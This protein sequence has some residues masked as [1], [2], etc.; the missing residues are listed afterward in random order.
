MQKLYIT[1]F[2]G[3]YSITGKI[4][5][6][7]RNAIVF[8]SCLL[9]TAIY[10]FWSKSMDASPGII[11]I[12]GS[13]ITA[14]MTVFSI[15]GPMVKVRKN[16][17]PYFSMVLFGVGILLIGQLHQVGDGYVMYALDLIF[18]FPA[19]YFIWNSRGDHDTLYKMIAAGILLAGIISFMYCFYLASKGELVIENGRLNAYKRNANFLGMMGV[20]VIIGST[21]LLLLLNQSWLAVL[22]SSAGIGIGLT[23]ILLSVSR[24]AMLTVLG[25]GLVGFV[26]LFKM[27]RCGSMRKKRAIPLVAVMIL[28]AA[29]TTYFGTQ[30]DDIHYNAVNAINSA[31]EAA[32]QT[33][34]ESAS[35]E[36]QGPSGESE[37]LNT[38]TERIDTSEGINSYSSGRINIWRIYLIYITPFGKPFSN[39][40]GDLSSQSETR[41][42]NNI[43]EYCY[44]C[45]YVVGSLYVIFYIATAFIGLKMLFSGRYDR[46]EDA[47]L[48]M[49][50]GAY[51]VY[52]M[53]EI[54]TLPFMRV[55][56]CLFFLTIAPVMKKADTRVEN[57]EQQNQ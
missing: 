8:L 34:T 56:P 14:V 54:S 52:A 26:F 17:L 55:I 32:E 33:A 1:I 9:L 36:Q 18:L 25:C 53:L 51:S 23:Y 5:E 29:V 38:I 11:M 3:I 27:I 10:F 39:I 4:D 20:D 40:S 42:H 22:L 50:I 49:V 12:T 15:K 44:R 2:N 35:P 31:E 13:A 6:R 24:T 46:P 48:I 21:Y 37:G 43:L 28:T 47:F 19:L 16:Y 57:N 30:L 41:A 45:G 7:V